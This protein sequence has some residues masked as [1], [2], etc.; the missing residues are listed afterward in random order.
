MENDE[1][2]IENPSEEPREPAPFPSGVNYYLPEYDVRAALAEQRR[3]EEARAA[4]L[5]KLKRICENF[6]SL[7]IAFILAIVIRQYVAEA[8]KIPTGSMQPTLMGDQDALDHYGDRIVVDKL[9]YRLNP[10]SR[11]DVVVFKYPKPIY[12]SHWPGCARY[13]EDADIIDGD[14]HRACD[15]RACHGSF[16]VEKSRYTT[17]THRNYVKRCAA[18]PGET[19]DI[20]HGDIYI[21]NN[22]LDDEIP[23]KSD[24][25]QRGLWMRVY[26]CDFRN[27]NPF[28]DNARL[29]WDVPDNEVWHTAE[30]HLFVDPGSDTA[31]FK[32]DDIMDYLIVEGNQMLKGDGRNNVGDLKIDTGLSF[33]SSEAVVRYVIVEDNCTY[34][35]CLRPDGGESYVEWI[36]NGNEKA[37]RREIDGLNLKLG[38][39]YGVSFANVDDTVIVNIPEC[40]YTFRHRFAKGKIVLEYEDDDESGFKAES[41]AA[42]SVTGGRVAFGRL[43]VLRDIYYTN[44]RFGNNGP[45]KP[46]RPFVVPEKSYFV[47]GDNSSNSSDSREW[48]V[49]PHGN[50]IGRASFV[51]YPIG[52]IVNFKEKRITWV[53]RL[54]LVR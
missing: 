2:P 45:D 16:D 20:K 38:V 15:A 39:E 5:R 40:S 9:Y 34:T 31:E 47:L 51:F 12:V 17:K 27:D 10:V 3:R 7:I 29:A 8:Y 14:E 54:K 19:I 37:E 11:W 13:S 46:S 35:L 24:R 33:H 28:L 4:R 21:R 41:G 6:E 26:L 44:S 48:G 36:V 43:G 50:L 30:K 49:F 25:V 18:L 53:N 22:D 32:L 1:K 42:V 52:P 23:H